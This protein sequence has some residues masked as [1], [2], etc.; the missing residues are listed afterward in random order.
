M[1][2]RQASLAT[3]LAELNLKAYNLTKSL[4]QCRENLQHAHARFESNDKINKKQNKKCYKSK[5]I[6]G[7]RNEISQMTENIILI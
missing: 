1:A 5:K 2:T 6:S 7:Q 4:T 3:S